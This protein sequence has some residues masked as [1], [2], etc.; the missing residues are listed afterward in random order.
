WRVLADAGRGITA[1]VQ[2]GLSELGDRLGPI[3]WQ[4]PPDKPFDPVDFEHFLEQLPRDLDGRPLRHAVEV[5]HPDFACD[6]FVELARRH[7]VA[8]VF[9]DSPEYPS[10]ADLGADFV[11]ARLMRSDAKR[12]TGY[13]A[14]ELDAWAGRARTWAS[15]GEPADLPR[16]APSMRS[17]APRA[18]YIY[19]IGAAKVRNPAA[20]MALIERL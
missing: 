1:F 14:R 9:T 5:R 17:A 20:A 8:I 12:A 18:V 2:G 6:R 10:F 11:Y 19:F 4:F 13:T 15:G 7:G 3:N 16:V